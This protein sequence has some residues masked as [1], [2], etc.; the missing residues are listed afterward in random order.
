MKA[1]II[2]A[3]SE[4]LHTIQT[5][6][7]Q[8]LRV[9]ALDGDSRAAGLAAADRGLVIDISDEQKTIEALRSEQPDFILTAPIGRYLTTIGAVNDA[10]CLPGIT[11]EMA[12][13]C[14]DK[15]LFHTLLHEQGLR[16]CFCYEVS[17]KRKSDKCVENLHVTFPAILKPRY[18]SGSRG[19]HLVSEE[20]Q[21]QEALALTSGE[22]YVLEE[23]IAGEEYGV[24]GAVTEAGFQMIL[25]RKKKNTPPPARQAV[26][27]FSLPPDSREGSVYQRLEVYTRKVVESLGLREC[28]FHA[29]LIDGRRGP[30]VIELSA[31]PSGHNLHN[32]FTPLCTGVDMVREY[33]RYRRG[34]AYC[35]CPRQVESMMIHYFD[36]EGK[37]EQ[38]PEREQVE[39]VVQTKLEAWECHIQKGEV[40]SAV[41]DGHSVMGRGYFILKGGDERLLAEDTQAVK[42]LFC[43]DR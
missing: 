38:V 16:D 12:L 17:A 13:G 2:G 7:E 5:A 25:L 42:R 23:W 35:F 43:S 22:D 37:V 3:G 29:D 14:T 26:A 10:L 20:R 21:L 9:V 8:G 27:Y 36:I 39:R 19:I 6:R 41:S 40:L 18:G 31:R 1:A 11:R 4:A 33:I 34:M 15:Y 32:L 28:L 24:D 30:F